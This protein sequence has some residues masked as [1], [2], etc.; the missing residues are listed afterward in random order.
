MTAMP[1]FSG[2]RPPRAHGVAY[3]LMG[4]A[5]V[6]LT[7]TSALLAIGWKGEWLRFALLVAFAVVGAAAVG[8]FALGARKPGGA[9]RA[10]RRESLQWRRWQ[11]CLFTF[12][13]IFTNLAFLADYM[14]RLGD[15]AG[16][17]FAL[18]LP[19]LGAVM[20]AQIFPLGRG[21]PHS[22]R[23]RQIEDLTDELSQAHVTKALR[24]GYYAFLAA[25]AGA[26][27]TAAIAPAWTVHAVIA[28]LWLG[29]VAPLI[30]F[31]LLQR[32]AELDAG[33]E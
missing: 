20:L 18:M 25:S 9:S 1:Q 17:A 11:S 26:L 30:H 24:S 3:V 5:T 13:V 16:T 10:A 32:A 33:E 22:L 21:Q 7:A 12:P 14:A 23:R 29:F 27:A 28:G 19:L 8:A 4:L 31:G 6:F 15:W 2:Y